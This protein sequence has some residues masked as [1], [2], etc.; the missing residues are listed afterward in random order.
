VRS[1]VHRL[2]CPVRRAR[3]E[4]GFSLIELLIALTVLMIGVAGILAL[5]M[6]A[7]RATAY[8]RHATE[9]TILAEDKM[10]ELRTQP[11][12]SGQDQVNAQGILD[13]E[14]RYQRVWTVT[15]PPAGGAPSVTVQV[16]WLERGSEPH[17]ITLQTQR[18][19]P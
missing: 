14:G 3:P 9:A 6:T 18:S 2:C 17:A 4:R 19:L 12:M 8:S 15:E 16:N 11:Y 7:L 5:Q 10:E 1:L 13:P